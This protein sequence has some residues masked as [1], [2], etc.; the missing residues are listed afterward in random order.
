[1][2]KNLFVFV[3]AFIFFVSIHSYGIFAEVPEKKENYINFSSETARYKKSD[4]SLRLSGAVNI[5]F[6]QFSIKSD[7]LIAKTN[8]FDSTDFNI[9]EAERNVYFSNNGEITATGDKLFLDIKRKFATIEGNVEFFQGGSII[10]AEKI[11]VDLATE[12]VDFEGI[13]DS[14]IKN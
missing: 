7:L 10:R 5:L 1:M 2:K 11:N 13:R 6:K 9:I 8:K 14:F 12:T 3:I 4:G